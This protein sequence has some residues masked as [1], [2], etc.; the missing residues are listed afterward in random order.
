MVNVSLTNCNMH[1]MYMYV[2]L[3]VQRRAVEKEVH[4]GQAGALVL[5]VVA[6]TRVPLKRVGV[7]LPVRKRGF[8]RGADA[9]VQKPGVARVEVRV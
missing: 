4:F 1:V 3:Y 8:L 7:P 5:S 6:L 9:H 2:Q